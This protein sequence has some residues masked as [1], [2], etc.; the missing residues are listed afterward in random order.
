VKIKVSP[1]IVG[2]FVLG[3]V[4]LGVVG[5]LSFGGVNFF[6]KPERFVVYFDESIH[7]LDRGSPV[8][9][10]GVRV[11]RVIEL[12]VRYSAKTNQSLVGV[13]CE[14]ESN[15]IVDENGNVVDVKNRAQLQEFVDRGLRA[16]LGFLGFATGLLFVELDFENVETHP[17]PLEPKHP[18]YVTVPAIPSAI[19]AS[20]TSV[21]EILG[22]LKKVDFSG[23]SREVRG[24]I[25]D[26]RKQLSALDLAALSAELTKTSKAVTALA[27]SPDIPR[28]FANL[29]N[30]IDQL[31]KTLG[32][33]DGQLEPAGVKLNEALAQTKDVLKTI[34]D[35]AASARNFVNAQSGVGEETMRTLTQLADA[36]AAVQRLADFIERNPNALL[37]GKKPPR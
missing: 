27:S 18:L 5:L 13:I 17:A 15:A 22:D 16:Q 34:N 23:L 19:A 28:T 32:H 24:L 4:V 36:A 12:N 21:T 8:K 31:N 30:A 29:N 14:L 25:V 37:T 3:A 10:R 2:L 7:G 26:V 6:H 33:V 1:S 35:A 9:L 20:L 11:G